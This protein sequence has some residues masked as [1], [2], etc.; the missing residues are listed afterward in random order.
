MG[1]SDATVS[2]VGG[3]AV[4]SVPGLAA[5]GYRVKGTTWTITEEF[6]TSNGLTGFLIGDA[7]LND[8]WAAIST[9]T[10]GTTGGQLAF[11]AGDEPI[12]APSGYVV[13]LSALS[14]TFDTNG[15]IHVTLYWES[16]PADVVP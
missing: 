4:I 5:A 14:G 15:T 16:L 13:L 12:T 8:R 7:L 2:T 9:L 10:A 6:G 3:E 1:S 11:H